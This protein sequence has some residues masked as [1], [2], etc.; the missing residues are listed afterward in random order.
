MSTEQERT[1]I[2]H[3]WQSSSHGRTFV[4]ISRTAT[5]VNVCENHLSACPRL[6]GMMVRRVQRPASCVPF[7]SSSESLRAFAQVNEVPEVQGCHEQLIKEDWTGRSQY[8]DR[9]VQSLRVWGDSASGT[10]MLPSSYICLHARQTL[11]CVLAWDTFPCP[12]L[13]I[14]KSEYTQRQS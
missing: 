3:E 5:C 4:C 13:V 9:V 1:L 14:H 11:N 10:W 8:S 7:P 6:F 2:V 12:E